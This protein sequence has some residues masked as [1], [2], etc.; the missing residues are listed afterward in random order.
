VLGLIMVFIAVSNIFIGGGFVTALIRKTDA[1]DDD[2]NTV[3]YC[4]LGVSIVF[5]LLFCLV[6]KNI[7]IFFNEPILNYVAPVMSTLLLIYAVSIIQHTILIK[8]IDFKREAIISIVSSLGSGAVGIGMAL[9]S[10]GVWSLVGQQLSRE[11]FKTSLLWIYGSWRPKWL[12]S[13]QSF[14]E[15]FYFGSKVLA[16]DLINTLYKN[17]FSVIVGK[18][19]STTQLGQYNRAEQFNTILTNNLTGVIVRVAFPALS[20]LKDDKEKMVHSFRKILLYSAIVTFSLVCGLAAAAKSLILLLIGEKWLPS[21]E[22]LQILCCYGVLYPL[23]QLNLIILNI[24]GRSDWLLKLEFL[25]KFLFIPVLVVGFYF[26]LRYM[27]WAAVVY[28]YIE[29]IANSWYSERL[30]G[31]GTWKQIKDLFPVFMLSIIVALCMCSVTFLSLSSFFTLILQCIS[32]LILFLSVYEWTSYQEYLEL[33][34]IV[35][36]WITFG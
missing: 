11:M 17:I 6:S 7:A 10:F 34:G 33:K 5:M 27:L 3:F 19:Y 22:Y 36:R 4:N 26:E 18:M 35:R 15:L 13:K 8:N 23:Q 30:I 31:Y 29:F 9:M 12:F 16:A 25:K 28:Y 20:H 14:Q 2:Y 21:V 1:H 32:G 24:Y